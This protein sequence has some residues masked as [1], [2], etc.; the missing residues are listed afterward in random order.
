MKLRISS[1]PIV[2]GRHAYDLDKQGIGDNGINRHSK[3]G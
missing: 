3:S 1:S 2:V